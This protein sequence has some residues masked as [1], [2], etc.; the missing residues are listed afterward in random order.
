MIP[1]R[2]VAQVRVLEARA[3]A[4]LAP[5]TLMQRAAFALAVS[6]AALLRAGLGRVV[7]ARI[8]VLAGPGGN[9][10]DALWAASFLAARGC[11]V[12][13]VATADAVHD[14][15]CAAFIAA[16]GQFLDDVPDD[17][18][19]VLDGIAGIGGRAGLAGRAAQAVAQAVRTGAFIVA[20]D[21]PSG[22]DADSGLAGQD[23][24]VADVTVTFGCL[25]P[26][27]VL[28]PEHAGLVQLVPIGL[29]D[30]AEPEARVLDD[31]DVAAFVPGPAIDAYKYARGVA[32]LAAGSAQYP[33]AALLATAGAR[34]ADVGMVH[35]LDRLDGIADLVVRD[36]PDVVRSAA[37]PRDCSR[38]TAWGCGPGLPG[39]AGDAD[40][41]SAVLAAQVPVVLDAG[42]LSVVA[43]SAAVRAALVA[44]AEAGLPSVLTPHEGEFARMA[45]PLGLPLPAQV[46]RLTAARALAVALRATIVLK[47]PGTVIAPPT[48]PAWIDTE[49]TVS[50]AT[51]GSGDVLTGITTAVLAGAWARGHREDLVPA[52]AAAVW[53]HGRA[54]R[55]ADAP[56]T[57][58]DLADRV[59]DAVAS[60][61]AESAIGA[62]VSDRSPHP[63]AKTP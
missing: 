25:K 57:A 34:H 55:L 58:T 11:R 38:V 39:D 40:V 63:S 33:G 53:L 20:V 13:A 59:Q 45:E 17:T 30:D 16:G 32:G 8:C 21:V 24:V 56:A 10:G 46:G 49:G 35:V 29:A 62:L 31:E 41:V 19:L 42:A 1:V 51:A 52:V 2:S 4:H 48:G 26:G 12:V 47:G 50:L 5:G 18:D 9:G 6:C 22:V 61:R 27:V 7:G 60:A 54:G 37:A 43:S 3:M 36:F 14:E 44:R 28:T 23:A 15:G